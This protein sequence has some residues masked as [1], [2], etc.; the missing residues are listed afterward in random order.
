M[1]IS[2]MLDRLLAGM[3]KLVVTGLI[4]AF[5]A[6]AVMTAYGGFM[7]LVRVHL[8]QA[9]CMLGI[10][11]VSGVTAYLLGTRRGDLADC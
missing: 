5:T 4:A 10:A 8:Q 1:L 7:Y 3:L 2:A 11:A 6:V 9:G